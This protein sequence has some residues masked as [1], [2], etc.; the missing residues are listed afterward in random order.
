[1]NR[2]T[3]LL[4]LCP[5]AV[6]AILLAYE[7]PAKA[8]FFDQIQLAVGITGGA[9]HSSA[10]Q[11]ATPAVTTIKN[12][13]GQ[14]YGIQCFNIL[15]TPVYIHSFDLAS[16]SITLGTT[17]DTERWMCPG[18]TAGAGFVIEITT[19]DQYLNAINYITSL[20][21]ATTDHTAITASSVTVNFLFK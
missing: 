20:N 4:A 14:L 11:P 18:N 19:G 5:V 12:S 3:K 8:S 21:M 1:M 2:Y 16:G 6:F 13:A 17:A 15:A 7:Q 9:G 10:I